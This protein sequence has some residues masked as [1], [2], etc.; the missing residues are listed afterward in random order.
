MN[1]KW[2]I[3]VVEAVGSL[4]SSAMLC[5]ANGRGSTRQAFATEVGEGWAHGVPARAI[6]ARTLAHQIGCKGRQPPDWYQPRADRPTAERWLRGRPD[7]TFLVR[8]KYADLGVF[9]ISANHRG[10]TTHHL[11]HL[12]GERRSG[13]YATFNDFPCIGCA[14]LTD[15]V[16][17]LHEPH[18]HWP[19]VLRGEIL[20]SQSESNSSGAGSES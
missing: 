6:P 4:V 17:Y 2:D 20:T 7:G 3:P 12:P 15:V 18:P 5:G 14:N 19:L 13:S 16:R 11:V 10:H 9:C 1:L 8:P